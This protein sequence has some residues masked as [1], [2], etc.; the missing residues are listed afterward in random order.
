MLYKFCGKLHNPTDSKPQMRIFE[1]INF[2]RKLAFQK[3]TL[4]DVGKLNLRQVRKM[5]FFLKNG[6]LLNWKIGDFP[7]HMHKNIANVLAS[8]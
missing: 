8:L 1:V 4:V 7:L 6:L 5:F 2:L 3:S